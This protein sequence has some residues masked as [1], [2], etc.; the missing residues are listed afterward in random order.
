MKRSATQLQQ[1]GELP[2]VFIGSILSWKK[3][4]VQKRDLSLLNSA[5]D[6][7][8]ASGIVIM[9]SGKVPVFVFQDIDIKSQERSLCFVVLLPINDGSIFTSKIRLSGQTL[10]DTPF[11]LWRLTLLMRSF[12]HSC[13]LGRSPCFA[14]SVTSTGCN[15]AA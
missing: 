6:Q 5:L 10:D 1:L 15:Y 13:F 3:D 4:L 8:P 7:L 9:V 14:E 2:K 12:I 11:N